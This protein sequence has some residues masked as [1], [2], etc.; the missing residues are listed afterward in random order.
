M[1]KKIMFWLY[2]SNVLEVIL[3]LESGKFHHMQTSSTGFGKVNG[4]G[5]ETLQKRQ[6][7]IT[8][9]HEMLHFA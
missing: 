4:G 2:T 7:L 6:E 8:T 3:R 9:L 1:W 5:E